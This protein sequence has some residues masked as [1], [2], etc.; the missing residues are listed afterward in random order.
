MPETET[1]LTSA[2]Q[3]FV[4][5]SSG[6][7]T[8]LKIECKLKAVVLSHPGS[9][10]QTTRAANLAQ[11]LLDIR[12]KKPQGSQRGREP[13]WGHAHCQAAH[14]RHFS[15]RLQAQPRV[16]HRRPNSR[17]FCSR[18]TWNLKNFRKQSFSPYCV[19]QLTAH[20]SLEVTGGETGCEL[21]LLSTKTHN[22]SRCKIY[23][24]KYIAK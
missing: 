3:N 6:F 15:G 11:T 17:H 21:L 2:L 13:W 10:P 22:Y 20:T 8:W 5:T 14:L 1:L 23:S 7:R 9:I 19:V 4:F 16:Q 12:R 18:L 24:A